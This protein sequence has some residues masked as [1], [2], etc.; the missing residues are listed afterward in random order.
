MRPF[1]QY[2]CSAYAASMPRGAAFQNHGKGPV[3]P[4][5]QR[6]IGAGVA[7]ASAVFSFIRALR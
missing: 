6:F 3:L 2:F 7:T 1:L 4:P 5:I